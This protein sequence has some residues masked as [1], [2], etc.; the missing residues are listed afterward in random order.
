MESFLPQVD[1]GQLKAQLNKIMAEVSA[2]T[3][4][5]ASVSVKGTEEAGQCIVEFTD[6]FVSC[7]ERYGTTPH[8][9]LGQ[10]VVSN[11]FIFVLERI[12]KPCLT[13]Y[14]R[15]AEKHASAVLEAHTGGGG[16]HHRPPPQQ[17]SASADMGGATG[18]RDALEA[19]RR[20]LRCDI[21]RPFAQLFQGLH[22]SLVAEGESQT[23]QH[24]RSTTEC[25]GAARTGW[26]QRFATAGSAG[27]YAHDRHRVLAA[28]EAALEAS[29]HV[30]AGPPAAGTDAHSAGAD[31][32]D[33]SSA[34]FAQSFSQAPL[35]WKN[36]SPLSALCNHILE[37]LE[38]QWLV[39]AVGAD[40]AS[41]MLE[42]L[43]WNGYAR[44]ITPTYLL[45]LSDCLVGL[46]E[47]VPLGDAPTTG[48]SADDGTLF[49]TPYLTLREV[50]GGRV[51]AAAPSADD[52]CV[53]ARVLLQLYGL[54]QVTSAF[55][56]SAAPGNTRAD[57]AH[58]NFRMNRSDGASDAL[59]VVRRLMGLVKV[60]H[61]SPTPDLRLEAYCIA[62]LRQLCQRF[63]CDHPSVAGA[64]VELVKLLCDFFFLPHH[65]PRHDVWRLEA[66]QFMAV[67]LAH[68]SSELVGEGL[69]ADL[70]PTT[71]RKW[72]VTDPS[73]EGDDA[74]RKRRQ[75]N[76]TFDG[77][78]QRCSHRELL[79]LLHHTVYPTMYRI[80][81]Q[82]RHE[83]SFTSRRELFSAPC[84]PLQEVFD[85]GAT[86]LYL[87]SA[88]HAAY[89]DML[90]SGDR[91][92]G[93]AAGTAE[94]V[95]DRD[96]S[97]ETIQYHQQRKRRREPN[98]SGEGSAAGSDLGDR[99]KP[100]RSA[101]AQHP[102]P[103]QP[104]CE[105]L[106]LE[107][108]QPTPPPPPP[109]ASP[110]TSSDPAA[111][112]AMA[113][114]TRRRRG[115]PPP[116]LRICTAGLRSNN[117]AV[118]DAMSDR[119]LFL[120]HLFAQPC[121]TMHCP[122][123]IADALVEDVLL[124]LSAA[125]GVRMGLL[126]LAAVQA[127]VP[128]CSTSTQ[129]YTFSLLAQR[130]FPT[131]L[132][133]AGPGAAA[134]P[135]VREDLLHP[136]EPT[137]RVL[138][139]LLERR[140]AARRSR[141]L[142]FFFSSPSRCC[143]PPGVTA[144]AAA[145]HSPDEVRVVW[146]TH[147]HA[148]VSRVQSQLHTVEQAALRAREAAA[149]AHEMGAGDIT[150]AEAAAPPA[151]ASAGG[152][153]SAAAAATAFPWASASI[154]PSLT[155]T[156]VLSP[157][158]AV[159]LTRFAALVLC[160]R[161]GQL[162]VASAGVEH[163]AVGDDGFGLEFVLNAAAHGVLFYERVPL[164]RRLEGSEAVHRASSEQPR[165]ADRAAGV[166][167]FS[168][169]RG[170][171]RGANESALS[172]TLLSIPAGS[173]AVTPFP[174]LFAPVDFMMW[175]EAAEA[176][177]CAALWMSRAQQQMA[178]HSQLQSHGVPVPSGCSVLPATQCGAVAV[179]PLT[180]PLLSGV[181]RYLD[182]VRADL[183]EA[184]ADPSRRVPSVLHDATEGRWMLR[185]PSRSHRPAPTLGSLFPTPSDHHDCCATTGA[186][187]SPL[188]R[189]VSEAAA[190]PS[191]PRAFQAA[192]AKS[193]AGAVTWLMRRAQILES[194]NVDAASEEADLSSSSAGA[195]RTERNVGTA[196]GG[197]GP[198]F[199]GGRSAAVL[200]LS[201]QCVQLLHLL[202]RW[203]R[204][205]LWLPPE[206]GADR[207][208]SATM[209]ARMR[210]EAE[211]LQPGSAAGTTH[212]SASKS[213]AVA[214]VATP[215]DA[216][217]IS[218]QDQE[219]R[220]NGM[221]Q[222]QQQ[223]QAHVLSEANAAISTDARILATSPCLFDSPTSMLE[224]FSVRGGGRL[225]YAVLWLCRYVQH[226]Q[227]R[228]AR[229]DVLSALP[230]WAALRALYRD[231][232]A[233]LLDPSMV[234][235]DPRQTILQFTA[236]VVHICFHRGVSP[237]LRWRPSH[238]NSCELSRTVTGA[239]NLS[240]DTLRIVMTAARRTGIH[241]YAASPLVDVAALRSVLL[242]VLAQ[243]SLT[244][245][246][247]SWAVGAPAPTAP[248]PVEPEDA[249][250]PG[251]HPLLSQRNPFLLPVLPVL[252]ALLRLLFALP[253]APQGSAPDDGSG[254]RAASHELADCRTAVQLLQVLFSRYRYQIG[255]ALCSELMGGVLADVERLRSRDQPIPEC[256][257]RRRRTT[258]SDG[259]CDDERHGLADEG[260]GTAS[261]LY[262][263]SGRLLELWTAQLTD[264][265]RV[266]M[267][268]CTPQWQC[269][270]L[271]AA[272]AVLVG[273]E[274]AVAEVLGR[275]SF[276]FLSE[277]TP[278]S[279]R[280]HAAL[281]VGVVFRTFP[282]R[283]AR[284]LHTLLAKARE[285]MLSPTPLLCSTS[286][287]A[288]SEAVRAAPELRVD[289]MYTLL[290]C[291]ATRG[292]A[293]RD[294]MVECMARVT[295]WA[296]EDAAQATPNSLYVLTRP[297]SY[298]H[299]C[300]M[301]ARP[302]L[303]RW[304]CA[305]K[306]PLSALPFA[307]F[308]YGT[309]EDFV[310]DQLELLLP[311]ALLLLTAS[312]D[313]ESVVLGE[314]RPRHARHDVG[315]HGGPASTASATATAAASHAH[316]SLF[317]QIL[318]V[319]SEKVLSSGA[320]D[321]EGTRGR[322][323]RSETHRERGGAAMEA[324]TAEAESRGSRI[325]EELRQL[326]PLCMILRYFPSVVMQLLAIASNAPVSLFGAE[327]ADSDLCV[328]PLRCHADCPQPAGPVQGHV[329]VR[330][331]GERPADSSWWDTARRCLYW[332]EALLNTCQAAALVQAGAYV[333]SSTFLTL[334]DCV[335]MD[336][337]PAA[338][339]A[340]LNPAASANAA[341]VL[342]FYL[343]RSLAWPTP[344]PLFDVVLAA[345]MDELL[346]EVPRL[347]RTAAEPAQ[348]VY[349][350][351]EQLQR[352]LT[353]V[354]EKVTAVPLGCAAPMAP[355]SVSGATTGTPSRH[356]ANEDATGEHDVIVVEVEAEEVTATMTG[357]SDL[358][359][360]QAWCLRLLVPPLACADV[361]GRPMGQ[362][363][364]QELAEAQLQHDALSRLFLMGNG[365]F[366]RSLLHAVHRS[367]TA[368]TSL[369]CFFRAPQQLLLLC[370]I[371]TRWC[372]SRVL[373]EAQPLQAVLRYL[374]HWLRRDTLA[375]VRRVVCD[376]LLHVWPVAVSSRGGARPT[377]AEAKDHQPRARAAREDAAE[378]AE[379]D[380][381]TC[382][383][384]LSRSMEP[385][386]TVSP[387]VASAWGALRRSDPRLRCC[388]WH[389]RAAAFAKDTAG[390]GEEAL[391]AG[392]IVG[393]ASH[394]VVDVDDSTDDDEASHHTE[395]DQQG[396]VNAA[397]QCAAVLPPDVHSW[398][399]PTYLTYRSACLA[400]LQRASAQRSL[401]TLVALLHHTCGWD[402]LPACIG[403]HR[404][405]SS[406]P[407]VSLCVAAAAGPSVPPPPA[408]LS[409]VAAGVDAA[410][411]LISRCLEVAAVCQREGVPA[412]Q[413]TGPLPSVEAA[414]AAATT[415]PCRHPAE[416]MAVAVQHAVLCAISQLYRWSTALPMSEPHRV[417]DAALNTA[418]TAAAA[419][420]P[421]T[422]TVT[423]S[424]N[425]EDQALACFALLRSLALS[426]VH[427]GQPE[428]LTR[429]IE[430]GDRA[431][432]ALCTGASPGSGNSTADGDGTPKDDASTTAEQLVAASLGR[433]YVQLLYELE[434]LVATADAP[435]SEVAMH[436]L[437]TWVLSLQLSAHSSTAGALSNFDAAVVVVMCG[438]CAACSTPGDE[439]RAAGFVED[440]CATYASDLLYRLSWAVRSG[441]RW[442]YTAMA[443]ALPR[444]VPSPS[445]LPPPP[446]PFSSAHVTDASVWAPLR[447]S[448]PN[449]GVFLC[450]F[451]IAMAN[452]YG[453]VRRSA[454]W[455]SLLPLLFAELQLM[456]GAVGASTGASVPGSSTP[457][458]ASSGGIAA[459]SVGAHMLT[460]L[461]LH[462]MCLRESDG[463]R[464][465][466]REWSALLDAC[467]IQR[468]HR[469]PHTAKLLM[470]T[471]FTCHV[472]LMRHARRRGL[473]GS[474]AA[475]RPSSSSNSG[476]GGASRRACMSPSF[477]GGSDAAPTGDL[478]F[479]WPASFGAVPTLQDMQGCYWLS[480]IP[481][482]H[483]ARAAVA[484]QEPHLALFFGQLS[485]ESLFGPRTG[486]AA[487]CGEVETTRS[488]VMLRE[489]A[490]GGPAANA[491]S[492]VPYS[493][494]FPYAKY[495]EYPSNA[496]ASAATG[497]SAHE[498]VARSGARARERQDGVR[499]QTRRFAQHI[500]MIYDAVQ[501]QVDVDDVCGA[502]RMALRLSRQV[503]TS[504]CGAEAEGATDAESDSS[505]PLS[506]AY[507]GFASMPR[508]TISGTVIRRRAP[509]RVSG[510]DA[511]ED[512]SEDWVSTLRGW[513][514]EV[515][516]NPCSL[517]ES[518]RQRCDA[519]M[520]SVRQRV[521]GDAAYSSDPWCAA[522]QR[523]ALLLERGLPSTA[524]DVLLSLDTR[525]VDAQMR[526]VRQGAA[527]QPHLH[528]EQLANA[529]PDAVDAFAL[530]A[531]TPAGAPLPSASPSPPDKSAP[532]TLAHDMRLRSLLSEAA[533]RC[534][535]WTSVPSMRTASVLESTQVD[536]VDGAAAAATAFGE[537]RI[538]GFKAV[539]VPRAALARLAHPLYSS[540]ST[541]SP[542]SV[543]PASSCE[544]VR[545]GF[546]EHLLSAFLELSSGKPQL[547]LPHLRHAEASL[548]LGLSAT[549]VLTTVV[550]A[551]ALREVRDCAYALLR[552]RGV[553]AASGASLPSSAP[554]DKP[555]LPSWLVSGNE[556]TVGCKGR[557]ACD[558]RRS[559]SLLLSS[560]TI[561][562]R[563]G[564]S[565]WQLLDSVRHALSQLYGDRDACY[566]FLIGATER[567]LAFHEPGLAHRW[568]AGWERQEE[569]SRE[570]GHAG[571]SASPIAVERR[572]IDVALRKA[573]I[574][575]ALGRWQEA[576]SLLQPSPS[577][578][579][580]SSLS[581]ACPGGAAPFTTPLEPRV[582]QQLML[583]HA[584]LQTVPASQL[585]RDP[586]L[587]RAAASDHTGSC[588]F[589]LARLCHTLASDIADRLTSS[590][591]Q[592]L[593]AGL[594]ESKRQHRELEAQLHAATT[595][596][597]TAASLTS[598]TSRA[599]AP[600]VP[601]R[602]S[603]APPA[604]A[605]EATV[606]NDEQLR[607]IRRR[608]RELS[609]DIKRLEE[610][611][612][613]ERSNYGLYRRSAL[614]AY[615][616]FLQFHQMGSSA[617]PPPPHQQQKASHGDA[618][619]PAVALEQP[620]VTC[621]P[622]RDAESTLHAVFGFVELWLNAPDIEQGG[623]EVLGKVLDKAVE[624]LPTAAFLPLAS[625]LTARLGGPR[626]ADR[627]AFLVGRMAHDYPLHIVWPLL[628][629]RHGRSFAKSREVNTMHAVDEAKINAAQRLLADLASTTAH[630]TGAKTGLV[631]RAGSAATSVCVAKQIQDAQLLSSAYLELAF[632]RGT[633][634]AQADKRYAIKPDLLLVKEAHHLTVPPP[635]CL[636]LSYA[637]S[638]GEG[639][640]S[641]ASA[642]A[643]TP[644]VLR[645][646]PHFTTPGGVNVPKVLRC[647]LSDGRVARQLLKAGDDLR[648]DALIEHVFTTANQLFS[649]R[650]AT[651]P[652]RVRTF[653]IVPLA[654]T[655]GILQWVEDTI[656]LG[657]YVTGRCS[658]KEE[659]PGAH[660]R[661]FP[662]EP[663]TRECRLQL[664]NA[665][666][667][668][669]VE[670]LLRLYEVFTPALHYFFLEHATTAQAFVQQ[671]QTFTR[672]VAT[673][674]V[675][676]YVV[677]LGDRHINNILLHQKTAEVVHIDLGI[678]FDQSKLLPVPELVPFRMTRNII[679]GL[680]V[681]GTEGSLRP[682]AEAALGL[683][684]ERRELLRTLLSSIM[685][686]PLARWVIAGQLSADALAARAAAAVEEESG[687][688]E[689]AQQRQQQASARQ[690]PP[691]RARASNADAA[692]TLARIDAKL[693][694][695]DGGDVLSVS[696]QVRKLVE[697]AQRV[698][699]LAVMFPG[700]SQWV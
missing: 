651:R 111:T 608:T 261:L 554:S 103:V 362:R 130:C 601:A 622:Q 158:L 66:M 429:S 251:P 528:E 547:C 140:L 21:I 247:A 322:A 255:P 509:L 646:R 373:A 558:L 20:R 494:L 137:Y 17:Q 383:V 590:E 378:R 398:S 688:S 599:G 695:Y 108:F 364:R 184:V 441:S 358:H 365:T 515:P 350:T 675:V 632:D 343:K 538:S 392:A 320:D 243:Q 45:R 420:A 655:A 426:V 135:T 620:L 344:R 61:H 201:V 279:V 495:E 388:E 618:G 628:A 161:L 287:L 407:E 481:A 360:W 493:V 440:L 357:A 14:C 525:R 470:D 200:L 226:Q 662:G 55:P 352:A 291:W 371:S 191:L 49:V 270:L 113:P 663:T 69:W 650:A 40:Y 448:P 346:A 214:G 282:E 94:S 597:T 396:E 341:D 316:R 504:V 391:A 25:G 602:G 280:R 264:P 658:G 624:R 631:V 387:V 154:A 452:T 206:E 379:A 173:V 423:D 274:P 203:R 238:P 276:E 476:G 455:A 256:R 443:T 27:V 427:A 635:T 246:G 138:V 339:A 325:D 74:L 144:E 406:S 665:P 637:D 680:G 492:S 79:S 338:G 297:L 591:H 491:V 58:T 54:A 629:L 696:T 232:G 60:R 348:L 294:L 331:T 418:A 1:S 376:A 38:S 433:A 308:G 589:L 182:A 116:V 272:F 412:L 167:A 275:F 300:R 205:G 691:M 580:P 334:Q 32:D 395:A 46:L 172:F 101:M 654:P 43:R 148:V 647:E 299:L 163:A 434:R 568:L 244:E 258:L 147:L 613:A 304:L 47:R 474:T 507:M 374:L 681:R 570:E 449:E 414:D 698:E 133:S 197:H 442:S 134:A 389:R 64:A 10:H 91:G 467:I 699:L 511:A 648:Q 444:S 480:D 487:L 404:F 202:L 48:E 59:A 277:W 260:D 120:L 600:R 573:Q 310:V 451:V 544:G 219:A 645:Y 33:F 421:A 128:H 576:L 402:D 333:W 82:H 321:R 223:Q 8:A 569:V 534:A 546:Y 417:F 626:D 669:K 124:P 666:P 605:R 579:S 105:A 349:A 607:L 690:V 7:A 464:A 454:M 207:T 550:A 250:L 119:S 500:F 489:A 84:S 160:V 143:T 67:V 410:R 335:A 171:A 355:P 254:G 115:I 51:W 657:E 469:C 585:V 13:M 595:A 386:L 582:V 296:V 11:V 564:R 347:H 535:Q 102:H 438:A 78:Q 673:S 220:Q 213:C 76:Q 627:L 505:T 575:Y 548:R 503:Q 298:T 609:G 462:V 510:D 447:T 95:E 145:V 381:W 121:A 236:E 587:S 125:L 553:D 633:T 311:F 132:G 193:V 581:A 181:E 450:R 326:A 639:E 208:P 192:L 671:Q 146:E 303:F 375:G 571:E 131:R 518:S 19:R 488:I 57:A 324:T 594:E 394:D 523:A 204:A 530:G 514:E 242:R 363:D 269:A 526:A 531:A 278:Y 267:P 382:A 687:G 34:V 327:A 165:Q 93:A 649:R 677:G 482:K 314:M 188:H 354:A 75:S 486:C 668:S 39:A 283:R 508:D 559:G 52:A 604:V 162:T 22:T 566:R 149:L 313:A 640:G 524:M 178:Q 522:L 351:P 542:S 241:A 366:L 106:E 520:D 659:H 606:L 189:V 16:R 252:P 26:D 578:S 539:A 194:F 218:E 409:N 453:L 439:G 499:A 445:H 2:V 3:A 552:R 479:S 123:Q 211:K 660:G 248:A 612:D 289:A 403:H 216:H 112:T 222:H 537:Q 345:H 652:L 415:P 572:C 81:T 50:A 87:C 41:L 30:P 107:F 286:L 302:H 56:P 63:Q 129:R 468:A 545:G 356:L 656:P 104:L 465:T 262:T 563:V 694:G 636:T 498:A 77:A 610:E 332:L 506:G 543:L 483:L 625:Q 288:L 517:E 159:L 168:A 401:S 586:F 99:P 309:L 249:L 551:E 31:D 432:D 73:A 596:G 359:T 377:P 186:G 533:W 616:R 212:S 169:D 527:P 472:V 471:L 653:A 284:V 484:V 72:S 405:D 424:E 157:S 428:M 679:D 318:G 367:C 263:H 239:L 644:H 642:P 353:W 574:A 126:L 336:V 685:H 83:Y 110:S 307:C 153:S 693:R 399:W 177:A 209:P 240:L 330:H 549:S 174:W 88:T 268:V 519:G 672:S 37:V 422:A 198:P 689:V 614:N 466:R 142:R 92:R 592:Q 340:M 430:Y 393:S 253:T 598:S 170:G 615:S 259:G 634:A 96:A 224:R 85:F 62:A 686:D 23:W 227:Q 583:W 411:S 459:V 12:V 70:H 368:P 641:V 228:L 425:C 9:V 683:L 68:A 560:A 413:R 565:S 234:C 231:V 436:A 516:L 372:S 475:Q 65:T 24:Q 461:L 643:Q 490:I 521:G 619:T 456:E 164:L 502:S 100:L 561:V 312:N 446:A 136:S 28:R 196:L 230:L 35:L 431:E 532:W 18:R 584:E 621:L 497:K 29:P 328:G 512:V 195:P 152:A 150:G 245:D 697:E 390:G 541:S 217:R 661:Y 151:G 122:P 317:E 501:Q 292:F 664:Q 306:H 416:R 676:G 210:R 176:Y 593:E 435:L 114:S 265:N 215:T 117:G 557:C 285:G 6:F 567:A 89:E 667:R 588:S 156:P 118:Q 319:Y 15:A 295:N 670:A 166:D 266:D 577:P 36:A 187:G 80:F 90:V 384:L 281:H 225:Y 139:T 97:H 369:E 109:P 44:L 370:V 237:L 397:M 127:V 437:R 496:A 400:P 513:E 385:L 408:F 305:Y 458:C 199:A 42:V 603:A 380:L 271:Q 529:A 183:K 301:H 98:D 229:P 623:S 678:A 233:V 674:S 53:Y 315:T 477:S 700:W 290:E 457:A 540:S 155:Y 536:S 630:R 221:Q 611:W 361:A 180:G 185:V 273:C 684:R 692:R 293:H 141:H 485:G 71:S 556:Q 682:C 323:H 179:P 555:G 175:L 478:P 419:L 460:L 235:V 86:V 562:L 617:A 257:G 4:D 342:V 329:G 463:Q 638:L 190:R 473:K 5:P 337:S